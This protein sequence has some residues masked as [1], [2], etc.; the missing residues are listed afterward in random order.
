MKGGPQGQSKEQGDLR[1]S[2]VPAL[3]V[4]LTTRLQA[5]PE[6]YLTIHI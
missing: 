6:G 5:R 2:G 1:I 3:T 4:T